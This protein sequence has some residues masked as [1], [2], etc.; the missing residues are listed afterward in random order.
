MLFRSEKCNGW[1]TMNTSSIKRCPSCNGSGQKAK[2]LKTLAGTVQV[3]ENCPDCHG[4]GRTQ[5]DDCDGCRGRGIV[6]GSEMFEISI[7][8]GQSEGAK[9]VFRG[10]GNV[11][12]R[13]GIAGDLIISIEYEK[14]P[15][16]IEG[17]DLI[18]ALNLSLPDAIL[19]TEV[20]IPTIEG[21][22]KLKIPPACQAGKIF[23]FK[24][25][26]LA[27]VNEYARGDLKVRVAVKMPEKL[28][29]EEKRIVEGL[30]N[31]E[32]FKVK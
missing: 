7:P 18:Y 28:T 14:T 6:Q 29:A 5:K 21:K 11:G 2:L 25:Q 12:E 19:G 9:I 16:K 8:A 20:E 31:S 10:K 1:G 13:G 22:A 27:A 3:Q 15:Y 30:R 24:S 17:K 32:N 26:G 23:A 4:S